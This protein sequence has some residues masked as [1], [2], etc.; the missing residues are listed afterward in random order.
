MAGIT[1]G[2]KGE[3]TGI[4]VG[5]GTGIKAFGG[6][7]AYTRGDQVRITPMP[8]LFRKEKQY[9]VVGKLEIREEYFP[10]WVEH[11]YF[12]NGQELRDKPPQLGEK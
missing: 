10:M 2:D 5:R 4:W 6:V 9:F 11:R 3:G 7:E 1:I 12:L 8:A